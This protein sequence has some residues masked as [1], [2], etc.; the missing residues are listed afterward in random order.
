MARILEIL[1]NNSGAF[2]VIFTA[3]VATS[4]VVYAILT[5]K[6]VSETRALREAQTEPN[7][8]ITTQSKEYEMGFIDLIIQNFGSGPAY[9]I[10]F[11][12]TPDF[13]YTNRQRLSELNFMKKG[14]RHLAPNNKF[15]LFL[16][17][18]YE[19]FEEKAKTPFEI[20][21]TYQ[22]K[23]GKI[24]E[25]GFTIDFSELEGVIQ[26]EKAPLHKIAKSVERI[27]KDIGYVTTGFHRLKTVVYTKKDVEKERKQQ[28]KKF[29]QYKKKEKK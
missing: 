4:A 26:F 11:R 18:L 27:Q 1:N 13:K 19:D 8:S 24:Y 10:N 6:L 22:N 21:V 16:T 2:S 14:L 12:I 28:L 20:T 9:N 29:E 3:V 5:G 17:S 15:Q 7:I 25:D 23:M